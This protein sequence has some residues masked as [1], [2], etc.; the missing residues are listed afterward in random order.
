[1]FG[2]GGKSQHEGGDQGNGMQREL[3]TATGTSIE[4]IQIIQ[5]SYKKS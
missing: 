4:E 3:A 2:L 1:L 5:E